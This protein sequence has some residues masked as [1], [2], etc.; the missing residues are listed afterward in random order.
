MKAQVEI[1]IL[2]T[3]DR[4]N[5]AIMR[6]GNK[7][8][9][10]K[11]SLDLN[12][13]FQ[14][15]YVTVSQ[16]VEPI[17]SGDWYYYSNK[18]GTTNGEYGISQLNN[19]YR[20][21]SEF[22]CRK[23]IGSSDPNLNR[24]NELNAYYTNGFGGGVKIPQLSKSFLREFIANPKSKWEVEYDFYFTDECERLEGDRDGEN[25]QEEYKLK[26]NTDN[27]INITAVKE[28][29]YSREEVEELLWKMGNDA[30]LDNYETKEFIKNNL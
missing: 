14:H 9:Y 29:M 21:I 4:T 2:P 30:V 1:I 17:K 25:I 26:V 16:D 8:V 10:I 18:D 5:I 23:I 24:L 13:G 6:S 7:L 11:E 15:L 20:K 28:K 3:E 19:D 12:N 22:N 27:T